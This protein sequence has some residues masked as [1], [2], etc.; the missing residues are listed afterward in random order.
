MKQYWGGGRKYTFDTIGRHICMLICSQS[1]VIRTKCFHVRYFS[2]VHR[3]HIP[4]TVHLPLAAQALTT[5]PISAHYPV[6]RSLYHWRR[7]TCWVKY[8]WLQNHTRV[9]TL[10]DCSWL[11]WIPVTNYMYLHLFARV[12]EIA[13]LNILTSSLS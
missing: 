9:Y 6:A 3:A 12:F 8:Y 4:R 5:I 2:L 13:I 7:I 1:S 11:G 10:A